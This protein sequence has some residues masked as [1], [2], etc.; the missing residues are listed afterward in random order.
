MISLR[1]YT[2]AITDPPQVESSL[3]T[4]GMIWPLE[5][6]KLFVFLVA[7]LQQ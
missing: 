2:W 6:Q 3:G 1:S 4:A 7:G 5:G